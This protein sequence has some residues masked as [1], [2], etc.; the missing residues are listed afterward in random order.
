MWALFALIL[1]QSVDYSAEGAK[2]LDAQ[3]YDTAL[4]LFTK[5]VAQDPKDYGPQFNLALTY[6]LM[7]KYADSIAHYKTVL[8]LKP[9][10]FEAELNLGISEL[11]AKDAASAAVQ[12]EAAAEQKPGEFRPAFYLGEALLENG[13]LADAEIAYAKAVALKSDSAEAEWGLAQTLMREKKLADSEPHFRK[14][15]ALNPK[16]KSYLLDL[17]SMF[18]A[19]HQ[20]EKAI[21][22]YREFPDDTAAKEHLGA[23]LVA[24][25]D[26]AAAIAFL[27]AAAAKSPTAGNRVALAQAYLMTKQD[28]KAVA[29]TAQLV[30]AEPQAYD[31]RMFAGKLLLNVHKLVPAAAQF[32]AATQIKPDS[33]EAWKELSALL[34]INQDYQ[35]G[36]AALDRLRALGVETSGQWFF[37]A[38][39][40]DHLHQMKEALAAYNKFLE[41]SQ[42]KNPDEEFKARQRARIIQHELDKR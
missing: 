2:A 20:P 32:S 15:A 26:P 31:V 25:G 36:I 1:A 17:A 42:G 14:A 23:L 27:E 18:E 30:A 4:D 40:Y 9:G 13:A 6:S 41:T 33:I 16:Y 34:V 24:S 22:L 39:S 38:L 37:R 12:L 28:D 8:E 3:K 10:L 19:D 11:R 29:V 5:A 21:A 7:G 35:G